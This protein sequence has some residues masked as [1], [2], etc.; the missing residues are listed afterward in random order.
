MTGPL[1][2]SA[3]TTPFAATVPLVVVDAGQVRITG[4]VLH[5]RNQV[6]VSPIS[7]DI[8][9]TTRVVTDVEI[10]QAKGAGTGR[11]TFVITTAGGAWKGRFEGKIDGPVFSGTFQ[12][13]G[14]GAMEGL[15]IRGTF[16]DEADP[17]NNVF[18]LTGRIL[19]PNAG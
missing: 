3:I 11:G 12:G 13:K 2:A 19:D 1:F 15:K 14:G 10:V 5:I 4:G 18:V 7:G 17:V 16:S 6:A 8:V 9:G